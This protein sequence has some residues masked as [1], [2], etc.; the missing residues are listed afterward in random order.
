[1]PSKLILQIALFAFF[2]VSVQPAFAG[3]A[4]ANNSDE[5]ALYNVL[6]TQANQRAQ[7]QQPQTPAPPN[8][9]PESGSTPP[10]PPR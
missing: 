10:P 3:K 6:Q 1:M 4:P 8:P 9:A 5:E 2:A 7:Q